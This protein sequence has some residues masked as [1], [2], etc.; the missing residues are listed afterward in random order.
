MP[1]P[2]RNCAALPLLAATAVCAA[3]LLLRAAYTGELTYRWLVLPNLILAWIPMAAAV[4][5][6]RS[7]GRSLRMTWFGW[8]CGA[9]WLFF[10]PNAPYIVTDLV[11]LTYMSSPSIVHFDLLL[12]MLAAMT[13]W[14]LGA[15][16][17][18]RLHRLVG[19]VKGSKAGNAF[20][21]VVLLLGSIGVYLGRFLRW[22][23]WDIVRHPLRIAAD[24]ISALGQPEALLFIAAFTA[25]SA[26][27][28]A[29]FYRWSASEG[30]C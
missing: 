14:F 28:Y 29:V 23:S 9:V 30:A 27:V 26:S 11:H 7:Y 15:V 12:N 5:V 3:M 19:D 2:Y 10:Y 4:G 16:S 25:F 24:S 21:A 20:A 22:N 6:L 1:Q 8:A 18:Y 17:L 13:G